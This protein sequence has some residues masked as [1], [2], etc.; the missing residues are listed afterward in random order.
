MNVDGEREEVLINKEEGDETDCYVVGSLLRVLR[1][2]LSWL[3]VKALKAKVL[4]ALRKQRLSGRAGM[5]VPL[6][7]ALLG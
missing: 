1:G 5:G 3:R 6:E 2:D 7:R 4:R